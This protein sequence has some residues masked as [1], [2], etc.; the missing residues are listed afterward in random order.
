MFVLS[1]QNG[2]LNGHMSFQVKITTYSPELPVVLFSMLYKVVL[3]F[4]Y[5]N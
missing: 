1:D 2:D 5:V 4:E 3:T